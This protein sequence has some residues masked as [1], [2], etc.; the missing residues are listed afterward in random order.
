MIPLAS[1]NIMQRK[2]Q[3]RHTGGHGLFCRGV[4][5]LE[6]KRQ[7]FLL[8]CCE[9]QSSDSHSTH[10]SLSLLSTT[11]QVR[12]IQSNHLTRR[13]TAIVSKSVVI[14]PPYAGCQSV[15]AIRLWRVLAS[16]LASHSYRKRA[17]SK[18]R[19]ILVARWF[20]KQ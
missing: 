10:E 18:L 16:L 7:S 20:F 14:T 13:R 2:R 19:I 12:N 1:Q 17:P 4:L 5:F 6:L 15:P 11:N 9:R 3:P 8:C